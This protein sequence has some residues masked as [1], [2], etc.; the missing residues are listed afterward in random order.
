M[1]CTAGAEPFKP[2]KRLEPLSKAETRDDETAKISTGEPAVR[3]APGRGITKGRFIPEN[4]GE[5]KG[6][7]DEG[8]SPKTQGC[9]AFDA[10]T[11][12]LRDT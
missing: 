4:C 2:W 7:Y 12:P 8:A 3:S 10:L 1:R 5:R 6:S 11:G 9:P